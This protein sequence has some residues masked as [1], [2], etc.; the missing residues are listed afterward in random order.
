MNAMQ[1]TFDV[2]PVVLS[3]RER[4]AL[5]HIGRGYTQKEAAFEMGIAASTLRVLLFRASRKLRGE[6]LQSRLAS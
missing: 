1:T 3:Q 4:Q 2:H 5:E 6:L